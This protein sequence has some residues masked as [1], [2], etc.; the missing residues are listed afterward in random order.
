MPIDSVVFD[1]ETLGTHAN[2]V[3]LSV[4]AVAVD[5]SKEYKY[6]ELLVN[7]FYVTMEVKSQVDAGRK[8]E[9]DT[10]DWW[11]TQGE[12]AMKV[13]K[14]SENDMHWSK[15]M[16][17]ISDWF[18]S[19]DINSKDVLVYSRGSH[20]DF[21]I[22][23]DL[24]RVTGNATPYELPWK[25]WNIHDS[26]TVVHTLLNKTTQVMPDGFIHHNA[27]HDAAREY[28]T[29]QTAIEQ[30]QTTLGED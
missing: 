15:L 19:L 16:P 9:K 17:A 14:P 12:D 2:A 10:L 29:I 24:F 23:H 13:L 3:I 25:W 5:S 7:G 8:I 20:F 1:L 30:F 18:N 4:G 6:E 22:M 26:K 11:A 28:M 27:L 21:S